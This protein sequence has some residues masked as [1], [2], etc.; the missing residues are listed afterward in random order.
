MELKW[1][2]AGVKATWVRGAPPPVK[3]E[4]SHGRR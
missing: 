4:N 3:Q 2:A 1:G